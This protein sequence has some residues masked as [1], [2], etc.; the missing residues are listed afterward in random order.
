MVKV[1]GCSNHPVALGEAPGWILD[2]DVA[3]GVACVIRGSIDLREISR[4]KFAATM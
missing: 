4:L 2:E 1:S 3:K